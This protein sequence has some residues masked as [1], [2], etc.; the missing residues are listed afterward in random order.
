MRSRQSSDCKLSQMEE[1]QI[2]LK[3]SEKIVLNSAKS[4][5]SNFR[6][7]QKLNIISHK[8]IHQTPISEMKDSILNIESDRKIHRDWEEVERVKNLV[9]TKVEEINKESVEVLI[10]LFERS[11]SF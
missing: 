3:S 1:S 5:K 7:P 4:L 2:T 6:T 11:F 10:G 8:D 9:N